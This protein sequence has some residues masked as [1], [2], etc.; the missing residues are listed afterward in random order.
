M[1]WNVDK[2]EHVGIKSIR[3]ECLITQAW[4]GLRGCA[5]CWCLA[6]LIL[7]G[8]YGMWWGLDEKIEK[9]VV[10]VKNLLGTLRARPEDTCT[11]C[12]DL[13]ASLPSREQWR[14]ESHDCKVKWLAVCP[15]TMYLH[16]PSSSVHLCR[17]WVLPREL[18]YVIFLGTSYGECASYEPAFSLVYV[19]LAQWVSEWAR[20]LKPDCSCFFWEP[21]FTSYVNFMKWLNFSGPC[22]HET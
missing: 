14:S 6:R 18:W 15:R 2:G 1:T 22:F 16:R 12:C 4:W 5:K 19:V 21:F 10:V 11:A 3:R 9:Q 7:L 8:L 13:E 17:D 20:I